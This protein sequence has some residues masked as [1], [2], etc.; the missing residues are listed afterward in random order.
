VKRNYGWFQLASHLRIPL[1]ETMESHSERDLQM[2]LLFLQMEQDIPNRSDQYLMAIRK[3]L[4]DSKRAKGT[5]ETPLEHFRLK[6]IQPKPI[7]PTTSPRFN[8]DTLEYEKAIWMGA[9]GYKKS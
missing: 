1:K 3:T 2:W 4:V 7:K 6:F 8:A 9:V 5:P